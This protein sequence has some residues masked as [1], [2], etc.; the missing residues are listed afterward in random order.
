MP[1]ASAEDVVREIARSEGATFRPAT[2]LFRDFAIRCRQQGV[3]S[4]QIDLARFRRMFASEIGGLG[5]LEGA[6]RDRVEA[7]IAGVDDDV[8]APYLAMLIAEVLGEPMP[9]EEELARLYGSS[10]PSR[11]RRLLYHLERSGLIVVREEFGG[12]RVI[13]VPGLPDFEDTTKAA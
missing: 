8:L 13:T 5:R 10:S 11:I 4:A 1:A 3:A 7:M 12:E 6:L 2:A 9:D